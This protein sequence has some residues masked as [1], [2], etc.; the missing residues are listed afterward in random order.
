MVKNS[1]KMR[2]FVASSIPTPVSATVRAHVAGRQAGPL[3]GIGLGDM[4]VREPDRQPAA[5]RHRV[6]GIDGEVDDDLLEL[7]GV[8]TDGPQVERRVDGHRHRLAGEVPDERRDLGDRSRRVHDLR[9]E[10]L[11][12]AEGEQLAGQRRAPVGGAD[13]LFEVG[14]T[15]IVGREVVR[16]EVGVAADREDEVVEVVRDAARELSDRFHLLG[17]AE[18]R[19]KLRA[20]G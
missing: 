12:A 1:S 20:R 14:P 3:F 7:S 16:H 8:G 6:A 15:W 9:H 5:R 10:H 4:R 2:A 13:D 11:P 19:L 17:V 18:L